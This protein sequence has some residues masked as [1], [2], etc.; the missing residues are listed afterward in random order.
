MGMKSEQTGEEGDNVSLPAV[1]QEEAAASV[2]MDSELFRVKSYRQAGYHTFNNTLDGDTATFV[3]AAEK[4]AKAMQIACSDPVSQIAD[5]ADRLFNEVMPK[6]LQ[7]GRMKAKAVEYLSTYWEYG[8]LLK[9]YYATLKTAERKKTMD[10]IGAEIERFKAKPEKKAEMLSEI[11]NA[12]NGH[13]G[14]KFPYEMAVV[15]ANRYDAE[16]NR[17]GTSQNGQASDDEKKTA[18]MFAIESTLDA[19]HSQRYG[20]PISRFLDTYYNEDASPIKAAL[21]LRVA[22]NRSLTGAAQSAGS[23]KY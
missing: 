15:I 21:T 3:R 2:R 8:A 4:W 12:G 1:V 19:G 7:T 6:Y 14:Y 10:D 18:A 9:K 16:L 23:G 22:A 17:L 11:V 13:G 20:V 5:V